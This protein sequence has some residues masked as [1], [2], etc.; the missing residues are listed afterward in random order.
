[1]HLIIKQDRNVQYGEEGLER[2]SRA[3]SMT[4]LELLYFF[5]AENWRVASLLEA[6]VSLFIHRI[7]H[8]VRS[9]HNLSSHFG[10]S[11]YFPIRAWRNN[12]FMV[13]FQWMCGSGPQIRSESWARETDRCN[14]QKMLLLLLLLQSR[15]VNNLS[16]NWP[17]QE[18]WFCTK[19]SRVPHK[20]VFAHPLCYSS[21]HFIHSQALHCITMC[22]WGE[23]DLHTPAW[24]GGGAGG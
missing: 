19:V 15:F 18:L 11:Q 12:V 21:G 4:R 20:F 2:P 23:S 3:R 13:L 16:N 1:M 8:C 24:P 5:F 6:R 14:P 7:N 22:T 17:E 10:P 9:H